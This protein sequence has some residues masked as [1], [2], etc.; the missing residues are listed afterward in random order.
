MR[1]NKILIIDDDKEILFAMSAIC[2]YK[3]WIAI[4]ATSVTE[5]IKK[6]KAIKPDIIIIDYHLPKINGIEGVK[7]IKEMFED[8]PIVVLTVE[9]DQKVADKFIEAGANDFALKPIKA[10]D[11][12]S[13]I[14]IHLKFRDTLKTVNKDFNECTK[15]IS[16]E[17]LEKIEKFMMSIEDNRYVSINEIS[18]NTKLAYQTVHRYMQYLLEKDRIDIQQIYGRIGRPRQ[19]YKLKSNFNYNINS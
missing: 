4:T 10:P 8:I 14:S 18:K 19:K 1:K 5:G 13:R 17:T 7:K 12:I 3:N 2:E 6:L 11:I 9:E 16:A 15:G